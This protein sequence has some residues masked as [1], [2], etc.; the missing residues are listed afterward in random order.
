MVA[1]FCALPD[2]HWPPFRVLNIV[3]DVTHEGLAAIPN[4]SISGVRVPAS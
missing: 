3:D 2:G 4:A 1:G